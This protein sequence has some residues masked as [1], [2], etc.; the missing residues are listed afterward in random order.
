MVLVQGEIQELAENPLD[1]FGGD[2]NEPK[3]LSDGTPQL[4]FTLWYDTTFGGAAGSGA[5][6]ANFDSAIVYGGNALRSIAINGGSEV[7]YLLLQYGSLQPEA[8]GA[9]MEVTKWLKPSAFRA[10]GRRP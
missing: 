5:E 10:A 9:V 4:N 7:N 6:V 3:S 2:V 8:T 1:A